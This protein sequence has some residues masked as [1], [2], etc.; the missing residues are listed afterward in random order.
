MLLVN[1]LAEMRNDVL[2]FDALE[3]AKG[4]VAV[5]KL[6]LRLRM[7]LHGNFVDER[8]VVA[9][10]ERVEKGEVRIKFAEK[11][12]KWQEEIGRSNGVNGH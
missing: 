8:D 3:V 4:P 6:P 7:G 9:W 11:P 12:L 5:L 2:L 10:R 1:R